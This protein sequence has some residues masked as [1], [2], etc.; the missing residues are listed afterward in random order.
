MFDQTPVTFREAV[1]S[2]LLFH[3]LL[4]ILVLM[5]PQVFTS[6]AEPRAV[7]NPEVPVHVEFLQA[8]DEPVTLPQSLSLGDKGDTLSSDPRP[9]DAPAPENDDPYAV[10]NNPNRFMAPPVAS[11]ASP[12]PG[13]RGEGD[14]PRP[15]EAGEESSA[16]ADAGPSGESPGGED[17]SD[18]MAS[19]SPFQVPPSGS[20]GP[21][22]EGEASGDDRDKAASLKD[23]L[24]RMSLGMS[25]GAPLRFNNPVGGLRGPSGGLSFDTPGFDWGPYARK[26]YWIIWTN[27]TQGWPPAAWAGQK[28]VV[29]VRFRIWADGT[30][31]DIEVLDESGTPAFDL[32]ATVALEAS[33]PL[34]PLP[35]DFPNESEGVTARFLYNMSSR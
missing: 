28:G 24:G 32:C 29:T 3:A 18:R 35:K 20:P 30:I 33:S 19:L 4:I 10:G 21:A 13:L 14:E 2:S 22:G 15:P 23:A 9:P 8:P 16:T 11:E 1:L 17:L 12:D 27:W 5:F 6:H 7:P 25:G 26:I 34:P 31:S